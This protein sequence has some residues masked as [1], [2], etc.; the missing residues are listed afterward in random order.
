MI[1]ARDA[2][3]SLRLPALRKVAIGNFQY[4]YLVLEDELKD[5]VCFSSDYF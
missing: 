5:E 4:F 1:D 3:S 2:C